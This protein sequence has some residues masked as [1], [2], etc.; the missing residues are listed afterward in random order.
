M[1]QTFS[2]R[3]TLH[4]QFKIGNNR[5]EISITAP[6][7]DPVNRP[8]YL[9]HTGFYG[10]QRIRNGH[11]TIVV[12]VNSQRHLTLSPNNLANFFDFPGHRSAI[13]VAEND[14]LGAGRNGMT[15]SLQRV[16]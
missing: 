7:S 11:F 5:T 13:G 8:L 9:H 16:V 2:Q 12:S 15:N 3:W 14:P 6:F 4:L 1:A 10:Y